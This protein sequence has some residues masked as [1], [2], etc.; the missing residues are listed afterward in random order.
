MRKTTVALMTMVLTIG[1]TPLWGQQT[2]PPQPP[3]FEATP[4]VGQPRVGGVEGT[5][6]IPPNLGEGAAG[7]AGGAGCGGS[8]CHPQ[9][10]LL[11]KLLVWAT[12]YPKERVCSCTS[13]CNS[14]QY[15]SVYPPYLMFLNPKCFEG[16]IQHG[17]VPNE[18]YRGCKG[19]GHP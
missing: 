1:A 8:A 19:C 9:G 17:T 2:N 7:L 4:G 14:C 6:R 13:C 12:Y 15:K 11:R 10:C 3:A 18:C 5:D 16:S